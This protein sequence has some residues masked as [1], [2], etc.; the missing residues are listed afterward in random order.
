[1]GAIGNVKN[2]ER[3]QLE[4]ITNEYVSNGFEVLFETA[5]PGSN[6][7]FDAIARRRS[8]DQLV[9]IELVSARLTEK[10]IIARRRSISEAALKFPTAL[11]DFR[12]IDDNSQAL[13]SVSHNRS[14]SVRLKQL[15]SLL[16]E[17]LP[18][19]KGKPFDAAK[20]IL[21]L[22]ASY[23]SLLRGYG[24]WLKHPE[25]ETIIL[26]DLYN[27]MLR[28]GFLKPPEKIMDSLEFDIFSLHDA[29]IASTQGAIVDMT[30]VIQLRGHYQSLRKQ[31]KSRIRLHKPREK[32]QW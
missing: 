30:Y 4:L 10:Q 27:D 17:K 31:V 23:S 8:D 20:E 21:F 3:Y 1:M 28:C 5:L 14:R 6:I 24:Y 7:F 16:S 18:I 9:L 22:W 12:Y 29:V 15:E 19:V 13:L 25:C 26:L 2:Y 11:V 32:F